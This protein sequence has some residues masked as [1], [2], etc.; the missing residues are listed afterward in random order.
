MRA[1]LES[2]RAR[3]ETLD[4][5]VFLS[6]VP[7]GV[8]P[9][10]AYYLVELVNGARP[11]DSPLSDV[12]SAWDLTVRVKSVGSTFE[13][14]L[15]YLGAARA[16]LVPAGVVAPLQVDGRGVWLR[17]VRHEADFVDWDVSPARFISLDSYALTSVPAGA[18]EV[19]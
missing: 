19:S 15:T 7:P 16:V 11:D 3:V 10:Q 2:L 6:A 17:F 18:E 5:Q 4:R 8:T 1:E 9:P 13:Q 14:A 12:T